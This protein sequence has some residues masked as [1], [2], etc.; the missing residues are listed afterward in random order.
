MATSNGLESLHLSRSIISMV[1]LPSFNKSLLWIRMML[2]IINSNNTANSWKLQKYRWYYHLYII[3]SP[4]H[5]RLLLVHLILFH[6]NILHSCNPIISHFSSDLFLWCINIMFL[7][8]SNPLTI[9]FNDTT[10][11]SKIYL[12]YFF[13][14]I[15]VAS[16]LTFFLNHF[17]KWLLISAA[18]LFSQT[19]YQ[20]IMPVAMRGSAR[21]T[22]W[23]SRTSI[24]SWK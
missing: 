18:K 23:G 8:F 7:F 13:E 4:D 20:L 14:N 24:N 17:F 16:N 15:C 6:I 3:L 5:K 10:F 9:I 19:V 1:S 22:V 21:L 11:Y 2:Q 12:N